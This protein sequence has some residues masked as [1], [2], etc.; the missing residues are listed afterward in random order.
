[1]KLLRFTFISIVFLQLTVVAHAAATAKKS[2]PEKK[3]VSLQAITLNGENVSLE[4]MLAYP[5]VVLMFW[6]TRCPRCEDDLKMINKQ[7]SEFKDTKVFLINIAELK[8]NVE[9]FSS[10]INLNQCMRD[11]IVL[12]REAKV[13]RSFY[14][15]GVPTYIF[16][17]TENRYMLVF[18]GLNQ[19]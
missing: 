17:K 10:Y 15:P 12:D 1:M 11:K 13:E 8:S 5:K 19:Y 4:E 6:T 14:I 9:W 2:Q 7:C 18:F 16:L 3:D